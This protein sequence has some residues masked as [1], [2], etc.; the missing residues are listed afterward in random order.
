[1]ADDSVVI[2]VDDDDDESK[3]VPNFFLKTY[4][5]LQPSSHH[6]K[7]AAWCSV[8]L[9]ATINASDDDVV[10]RTP[11]EDEVM[12]HRLLLTTGSSVEIYIQ[13]MLSCIGDIDIM[14]H[15]GDD[16]AVA[17]GYGLL[18][19]LP[20]K[21]HSRPKIDDI[22]D[23]DE[24]PGY[25]YLALSELTRK[26]IDAGKYD[27]LP[28]S[29]TDLGLRVY[30]DR[31]YMT[32]VHGPAMLVNYRSYHSHYVSHDHV[33][34]PFTTNTSRIDVVPC[35]R[36]LSWPLQAKNWLVQHRNYDWPDSA[37]IHR[38]CSNGCDV[39]CAVHHQCREDKWMASHQF[40][41]SFSRAEIILLNSWMPVQ[42]IVYH[43]LRFFTK[44]IEGLRDIIDNAGLSNY[45]FK[46]LMMWV[47][48]LKP[49]S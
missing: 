20:A 46:T 16:L 18:T 29:F 24:Y 9:S 47:C 10:I 3:V 1:M 15:S 37:T 4:R 17:D 38:V 2:V 43:M 8:L 34:A 36:C 28:E 31:R 40:R 45:H 14:H 35:V 22:I 11:V 25:V 21:F 41:L 12:Q 30:L 49:K 48:E 42:Q 39:V 44:D 32:Q 13:P 33:T 5:L 26:D 27:S 23:S 6:V 7:A 19:N